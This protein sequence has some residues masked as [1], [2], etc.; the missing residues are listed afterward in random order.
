MQG[1]DEQKKSLW[2]GGEAWAKAQEQQEA[3]EKAAET[4]VPRTWGSCRMKLERWAGARCCRTRDHGK[5][6]TYILRIMEGH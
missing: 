5:D 6:C 3:C 2:A 4:R 1:A